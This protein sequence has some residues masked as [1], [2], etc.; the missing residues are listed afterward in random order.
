MEV[1]MYFLDKVLLAMKKVKKEKQIPVSLFTV[2]TWCER[3]RVA[4]TEKQK[5]LLR[6]ELAKTAL[7][8]EQL[9]VMIAIFKDINDD[10]FSILTS[11]YPV[12]PFFP[13]EWEEL[14][15]EEV[16]RVLI[17]EYSLIFRKEQKEQKL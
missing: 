9:L 14:F 4:K 1:N 3:Y 7:S 15:R 17:L 2:A 16:T 12:I 6:T 13:H 10:V 5:V 11:K 8:P